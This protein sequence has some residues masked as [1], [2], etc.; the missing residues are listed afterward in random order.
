MDADADPK[1]SSSAACEDKLVNHN[2]WNVER[3]TKTYK[4]TD[5]RSRVV[6]SKKSNRSII[7]NLQA[8]PPLTYQPSEL[9]LG[10]ADTK[11]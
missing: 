1:A 2:E 9:T 6:S 11:S 5:G 10:S 3:G 4:S 8:T 7:Q